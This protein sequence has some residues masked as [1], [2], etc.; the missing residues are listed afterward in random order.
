M[1]VINLALGIALAATAAVARAEDAPAGP[2]TITGSAALV[3]DYRFRGVSQTDGDG[4]VQGSINLNHE[5]GF[6]VGTWA[7][8]ISLTGYGSTE[9]DLYGGYRLTLGGTAVDVGALYYYYPGGAHGLDTDFVELYGS[10]THTLGP[11]SAKAGF[12]FD[13]SQKGEGKESEAYFYGE[14]AGAIP[15]TPVTLKGH[16]GYSTGK[17]YLSAGVNSGD[18]NYIDYSIGADFTYK[19]LTFNVSYVDTDIDRAHASVSPGNY[20]AVKGA[21]V[22]SLTAAF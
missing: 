20:H 21:V 7:S 17:G 8:A 19:A 4:A 12:A 1:K 22:A 16:F 13:P 5:S 6:Y 14:L 2:F 18:K 3:T 15:S 10:A 11:V 9:V